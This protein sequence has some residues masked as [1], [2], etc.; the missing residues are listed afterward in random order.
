MSVFEDSKEPE[1]IKLAHAES[2]LTHFAA[3]IPGFEE[4]KHFKFVAQPDMQP[5]LWLRSVDEPIVSLP[6]INCLLVD[7]KV[8]SNI[9]DDHLKLIGSK[10]RNL[11]EPY[12]VLKVNSATKLITANTKAPIIINTQSRQGYQVLLDVKGVK[13]DEPLNNL[14]EAL[15]ED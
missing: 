2:E 7:P 6:V 3:G 1:K 13:I 11:V 14:L 8:L 9:T 12:Y 15:N 5:F 4:L 10:E